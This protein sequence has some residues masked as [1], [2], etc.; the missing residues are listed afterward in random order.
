MNAA[1]LKLAAN[2]VDAPYVKQGAESIKSREQLLRSLL[3]QV[4]KACL[5]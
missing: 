4:G 1:N 3:A 2:I 5:L